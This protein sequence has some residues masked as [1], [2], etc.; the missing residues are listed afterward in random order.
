MNSLE[1]M[2]CLKYLTAEEY[3][4]GNAKII[5][6]IKVWEDIVEIFALES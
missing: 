4:E 2:K 1:L 6:K 3:Q 5:I